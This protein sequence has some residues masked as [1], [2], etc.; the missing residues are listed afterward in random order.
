MKMIQTTDMTLQK[1][2]EIFGDGSFKLCEGKKAIDGNL[3][4]IAEAERWLATGAQIGLWCPPGFVIIDIDDQEQAEILNQLTNTL[5]CRTPHGMHFY[6]KTQNPIAQVVKGHMPIGLRCD[7]RVAG[8]GY[9]VLPYNSEGRAWIPGEIEELPYWIQPLK[10]SQKAEQFITPN[11]KDGD[12]RNDNL[13]RQIMRLRKEGFSE[14]QVKQTV[15]IINKSVWSDSLPED[16]IEGILNNANSYKPWDKGGQKDFCLY[17][18]KG[19]VCGV[20][21]KAL[22][23]HMVETYPMFVLGDSIYWY[24]NGVFSPN[25]LKVK[26][27]IKILIA[28]PKYQKQ[29]Q[30]KEIF[31]LLIEDLRLCISDSACNMHKNFINFKNGMFD[32]ESQQLYPH[33]PRFLSTVQIPHEYIDNNT[34]VNDIQVVDLLRKAK[35]PQDDIDMLLSYMAYSMTTNN[36]M[37]CFMCLV[38]GSNTGKS[39]LINMVNALV[40]K[41]HRSALSIQDMSVR[42]YPA[43]LKDKLINTCADNSSLAL[44]DIGNLKK[45]TGN[46]EIMHENKGATP[47]FFLP[48]AKLWFSFNTMPLQLED[49]SDAFWERLRICEMNN[50]IVLNQTYVEDLCSDESISAIIP[51][52][53]RRLKGMKKIAPSKRSKELSNRLRSES[54]SLHA[55]VTTQVQRTGN[56]ADYIAKTDMYESYARFCTQ[57]DR[58]PYKRSN[59]FRELISLGFIEMQNGNQ[60]VYIGVKKI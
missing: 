26:D 5:K 40:G 50:K 27:T 48:F 49:K 36:N 58:T 31:N 9:C 35:L 2:V 51:V 55:F 19:S 54:D 56:Y 53:C 38:G 52:L 6:F 39:T 44:N 8:K 16:E 43:Q 25:P 28:E 23:D 46:D 20:N 11:A 17:N 33:D 45:I 14:E 29:G 13:L 15:M 41:Q 30:I 4:G 12:G 47:Y 21:H 24:E 57:E 32:I 18:E 7:T 1:L 60:S 3:Y 59:F 37:K 34:D 42:F 22:V 10:I